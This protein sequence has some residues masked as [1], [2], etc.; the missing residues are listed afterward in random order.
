MASK[1]LVF[2]RVER[3][4]TALEQRLTRQ[5]QTLGITPPPFRVPAKS[6]NVR[7]W[8]NPQRRTRTAICHALGLT[9]GRAWRKWRKAWARAEKAGTR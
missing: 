5:L 7:Q 6:K 2:P 1:R 8:I 4:L 9:S 3:P